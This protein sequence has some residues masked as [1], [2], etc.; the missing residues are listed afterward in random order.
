MREFAV[1]NNDRRARFDV[2]ESDGTVKE[3]GAE[4]HLEDIVLKTEGKT[5]IQTPKSFAL[6]AVTANAEK[7]RVVVTN[8]TL[9]C[10]VQYDTDGSED[11]LEITDDP[12][13]I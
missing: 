4:A 13:T 10:T 6:T 3:E 1:R 8:V 12:Q 7:D 2:F 5:K 9:E 11:A